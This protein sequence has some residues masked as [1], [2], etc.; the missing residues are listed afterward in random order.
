M[1][2]YVSE[3]KRRLL[4]PLP[5]ADINCHETSLDWIKLKVVITFPLGDFRSEVFFLLFSFFEIGFL[6]PLV[7]FFEWELSFVMGQ[8]QTEW[9]KMLSKLF[10]LVD[11]NYEAFCLSLSILWNW[12]SLALFFNEMAFFCHETTLNW[13][14][15]KIVKTFLAC[16]FLIRGI[17][18][19]VFLSLELVFFGLL[20]FSELHSFP[21]LMDSIQLNEKERC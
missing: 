12:F 20:V 18:L 10:P 8:H 1:K 2:Q 21:L 17:D 5:L 15:K 11:V 7:S 14:K 9:N 4:K 19:I 6:W 3:W 16:W 13:I